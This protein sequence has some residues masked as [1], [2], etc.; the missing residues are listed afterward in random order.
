MK[1]AL[2]KE[3]IFGTVP[4]MKKEKT[5]GFWDAF[6]VLSGYGV[7]TWCYTQGAYVASFLSFKQ[8]LLSTFSSH[9]VI[10]ALYLLPI[11]MAARYGI[12]TW[13]WFK[14]VFG[15]KGIKIVSVIIILINFPWYAVCADLFASSM[16]NMVAGFGFQMSPALHTWLGIFCVGLGTVL[17]LQGP[18]AI[19]WVTRFMVPLLLAVGVYVIYVA[20][21]SMPLTELWNYKPVAAS[22]AEY[23]KS[24]EGNLGFAVAWCGTIAVT[25]RL[26]KKESQGYWATTLSM[27]VVTPF[28]ILAGGVMA[29]AMFLKTGVYVDDPT[30][31]LAQLSG[32]YAA[33]LSLLLVAF[34]NI[35]TQG[36]GSYL[37]AVMLKTSF[38]KVSY[39]WLVIILGVY[40]GILT[41]WGQ[42]VTY[43]GAFLSVT[44]YIYAPVNAMLLVDFF[45]VRKQ[46]LSFRSAY[47]LEGSK[48]A[49]KYKGGFNPVGFA[50]L[51]VG[52]I[53]PI[54]VYNPI[55]GDIHND[56]FY[57][58]T[59][60]GVGFLS[61]GILYFVLS[62]IP[63]IR[64]YMLQDRDELTVDA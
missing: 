21:T 19:T 20:T 47:E 1:E 54:F 30:L 2:K 9:L 4:V 50:V 26:C 15:T 13:I 16:Q 38:P 6:L 8:L 58:L 52:T 61:S 11:I 10:L 51:I 14:S 43:F 12:D 22:T 3:A 23:V 31:M 37:Y 63:P 44:A 48:G 57:Y 5:Y 55:T 7:A 17:A 28:F 29:I 39:N 18:T 45:L 46:K 53:I 24:I 32:P 33:L 35:G 40:V 49:Y 62:K 60:T 25:A 59:A 56:I 36:V 64:K 27:G 41:V 34:A 42:L